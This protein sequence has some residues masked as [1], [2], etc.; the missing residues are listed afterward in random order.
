M[1]YAMYGFEV[2]LRFQIERVQSSA[3]QNEGR[4]PSRVILAT[5]PVAS[6]RERQDSRRLG[7]N[8]WLTTSEE[9]LEPP[10]GPQ[11]TGRWCCELRQRCGPLQQSR[12]ASLSL[13]HI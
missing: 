12:R 11:N 8:A 9:C 3:W 4:S 7:I 1:R 13:I 10:M 5:T 6:T 2:E